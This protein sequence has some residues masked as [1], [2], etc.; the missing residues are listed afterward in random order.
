VLHVQGPKRW[1][2]TAIFKVVRYQTLGK[3][4][5]QTRA[6]AADRARCI[7]T[8]GARPT[9]KLKTVPQPNWQALLAPPLVVVP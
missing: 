5:T 1:S 3:G 4:G 2:N 7:S 8:N 6:S 9:E